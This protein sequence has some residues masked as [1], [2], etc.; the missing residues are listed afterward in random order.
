MKVVYLECTVLELSKIHG[1]KFAVDLIAQGT[2]KSSSGKIN[3]LL[4]N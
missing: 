3:Y 2:P 4:I 1:A